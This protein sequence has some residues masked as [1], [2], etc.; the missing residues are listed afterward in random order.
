MILQWLF[1]AHTHHI[2]IIIAMIST[3]TRNLLRSSITLK[4]KA[5]SGTWE[6]ISGQIKLNETVKAMEE[7]NDKVE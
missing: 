1:D 7:F 2:I 3:L 6:S 5:F 4:N